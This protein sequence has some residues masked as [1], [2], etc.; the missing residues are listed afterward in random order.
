[1]GDPSASR[2]RISRCS[3]RPFVERF[4]RRIAGHD[5]HVLAVAGPRAPDLPDVI[6]RGRCSTTSLRTASGAA[7]DALRACYRGALALAVAGRT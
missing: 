4:L 5:A 2:V 3:T 6:H 7:G 1:M